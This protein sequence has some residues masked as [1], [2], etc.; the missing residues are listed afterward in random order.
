MTISPPPSPT[1]F[2]FAQDAEV[3]PAGS[4]VFKAGEVGTLMYGVKEGTVD[5][6]V[7]DKVVESVD[8]GGFVGEMALIDQQVRSATVIARTD[9]LLVPINQQRFAYL[10][11]QTP[12]FAL[13]LMRVL[14]RRLR[15]MD[16]QL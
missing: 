11:Q 14:V 6:V 16:A 4:V 1:L 13:E 8:P 10:V 12:F 2:R 9:C 3:F 5:V 15:Q 7:H